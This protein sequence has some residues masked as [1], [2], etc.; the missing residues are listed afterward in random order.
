MREAWVLKTASLL[1]ENL[2]MHLPY[3][4]SYAGRQRVKPGTNPHLVA[5][6]LSGAQCPSVILVLHCACVD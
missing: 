1:N 3:D 4:V 6:I 5:K 2:V